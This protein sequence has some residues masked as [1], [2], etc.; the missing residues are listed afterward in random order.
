MFSA[1]LFGWPLTW[2]IHFPRSLDYELDRLAAIM[3]TERDPVT[4]PSWLFSSRMSYGM[5]VY[6]RAATCLNTLERYLGEAAMLRVMRTFQMRWRFRHPHTQD[7][8]DVVNEVSGQNMTWFFEQFFFATH[9]FDYGV[10]RLRTEEKKELDLGVFDVDGRK[11]EVKQKDIDKGKKAG[12]GKKEGQKT[13]VTDVTIRRFGEAVLGGE[14]R[15]KL[16]VVF[17]DGSEEVR[18]W[19]G[20]DRWESFRFEKRA[21]AKTAELDPDLIWLIDSN[22]S[23]NSLKAKAGRGGVIRLTSRLLF[24]VQNYLSALS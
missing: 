3:T 4:T 6:M 5:N 19:D 13:Y 1:S 15:V 24:W 17:E 21:K 8:I 11:E 20:R 23:N 10:S 2:L 18:Y 14:A 12:R 9:N 22:L 7:F 16:R